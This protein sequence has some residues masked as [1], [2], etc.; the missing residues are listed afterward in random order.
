MIR[1]FDGAKPEIAESAYVDESAVVVGEVTIETDA[2][3]W[4]G[5]VLRGDNGRIVVR[6]GANVQD[7]ATI[8]EGSEIGPYATVGHNA[9]VHGATVGERAMV[10]MGAVVL[11]RS[12]IGRESLVGANSL[13][14]EGTEVPASVLVAGTPAEVIKEVED[15]P[16]SGAGDHYV[17]LAKRYEETSEVVERGAVEPDE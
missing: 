6:E 9:I 14:T 13:V 5:T 10:G 11:D 15:S 12:T 2:S 8:H 1:S 3:V 17:G 4:P 7:N 16:W